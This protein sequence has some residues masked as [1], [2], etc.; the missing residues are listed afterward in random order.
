MIN[1]IYDH[2]AVST[3]LYAV[4]TRSVGCNGL[5]LCFTTSSGFLNGPWNYILIKQYMYNVKHCIY[6][7]DGYILS[8]P[9][10]CMYVPVL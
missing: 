2:L 5:N 10:D 6:N 4:A 8:T 1:Y 3:E 7:V 9:Y